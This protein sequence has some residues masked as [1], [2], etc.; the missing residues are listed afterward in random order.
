MNYESEGGYSLPHLFGFISCGLGVG[1]FLD[2]FFH[3][4]G[5]FLIFALKEMKVSHDTTRRNCFSA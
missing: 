5:R 2:G 3:Y 4:I 1:F